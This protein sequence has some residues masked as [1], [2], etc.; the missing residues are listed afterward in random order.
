MLEAASFEAVEALYGVL[1]LQVVVVYGF[2]LVP[3]SASDCESFA[4]YP[5]PP[6]FAQDGRRVRPASHV[7]GHGAARGL[8][9][10]AHGAVGGVPGAVVALGQLPVFGCRSSALPIVG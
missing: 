5:P 1:M 9:V 10:E 6:E 4:R 3:W 7:E 8:D 2:V